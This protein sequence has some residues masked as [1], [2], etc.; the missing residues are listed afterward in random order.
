MINMIMQ[1]NFLDIVIILI[2]LRICYIAFQTGVAVEFFKLMGIIFGAY[3]ALHYYTSF[4]DMIG[5][6]VMPKE[7]PLEFLDFIVF[8]MLATGGYLGFVVLRS[9]FYR[10]IKLEAVPKLNQFGGLILGAIRV[11]FTVGLLTY[12]LMIS[13]VKYLNDAVK[14]SYLGSKSVTIST[15]AYGWLWNNVVSKFAGNEKF[16]PTVNEVLK[17]NKAK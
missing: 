13:S 7:M 1:F 3:V 10:F 14:Y 16:N 4:S 6:L 2:T 15:D 9:I 11:F 5:R 17:S 12:T 8:L